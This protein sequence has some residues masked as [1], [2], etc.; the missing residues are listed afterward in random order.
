MKTA[1]VWLIAV[2]AGAPA[3]AA[4]VFDHPQAPAAVQAMV[5]TAMPDLGNVEVLRGRFVQRKFLRELPRA[6][7]S[8]G[9]FLLVRDQGVWWHAQT[10]IDSAL[11]VTASGVVRHDGAVST[12]ATANRPP[13]GS[14]IAASIFFALF[15]LD[16]D[17]LS[18]TFDLFATHTGARWQVGLRPHDAALA[19]W[20]QQATVAG[21]TRVRQVTLYETA[22]DRTEIDLDAVAQSRSSLTPDE[23]RRFEP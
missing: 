3:L 11:T 22:G 23:R 12:P 9:E 4:D 6:L 1:L 21:D 14:D 17:A 2:L 20:F 8:A 13:P 15:A 19:Q 10:P 5:R 18:R 7:T 16:V